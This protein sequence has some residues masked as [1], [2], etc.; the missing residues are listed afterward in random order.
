MA[1][2]E[3]E[4]ND[5]SNIGDDE[6]NVDD[7]L[8]T[9]EKNIALLE[10]NKKLFARAKKAEGFTQDS[11]GNWVKKVKPQ[12]TTTDSTINNSKP[13][14][15]VI[16]DEVI[17]LR[18]EGYSKSQVEFI[19]KNGGRKTLEDKNSLVSIAI[20]QQREQSKAE[21][22]ASKVVDTSSLSDVERKFTPEQLKN[23][24]AKELEQIL[25]RA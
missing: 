9:E 25:P 11:N 6:Y 13:T 21:D 8:E 2:N 10:Q 1:E 14:P 20:S 4:I 5:S 18:L 19:M 3:F 22:A 12:A 7:S 24:S 15:Y 23:M 17:D 16:D